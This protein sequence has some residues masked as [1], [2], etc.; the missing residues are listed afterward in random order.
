MRINKHCSRAIFFISILYWLLFLI[1]KPER[2][3]DITN[4]NTIA[5]EYNLSL[6]SKNDVMSKIIFMPISTAKDCLYFSIFMLLRSC[7]VSSFDLW[8]MPIKGPFSL[9]YDKMEMVL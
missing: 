8:W 6:S 2:T 9:E 3:P 7:V 5:M 1:V 4:G